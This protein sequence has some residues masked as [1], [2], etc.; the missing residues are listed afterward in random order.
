MIKRV[1]L[2]GVIASLGL[3]IAGC[4]PQLASKVSGNVT[5]DG[6]A[7]TQGDVTFAPVGD[8]QIAYGKIDGSGNYTLRTGSE[9]GA[10]PGDYIVTVVATGTPPAS[11][12]PP[13]LL[14]PAK[15]ADKST[16][17]LKHTVKPGEN[18]INL[19]LVSK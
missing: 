16:S 11:D 13:P 15:Y 14:T 12:K 17:D 9:E 3:V 6:T 5:V 2:F 18:T 1:L 10:K 7:L 4:G 8:G 19:P